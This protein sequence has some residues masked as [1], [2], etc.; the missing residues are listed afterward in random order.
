M[1]TE[2]VYALVQYTGW[3]VR[4]RVLRFA[5]LNE[6]LTKLYRYHPDNQR[7]RARMRHLRTIVA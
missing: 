2:H 6:C 3:N 1:T 4:H 7:R 5:S